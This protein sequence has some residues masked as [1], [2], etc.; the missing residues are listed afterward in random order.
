MKALHILILVPG[1]LVLL[2]MAGEVY[3]RSR[4]LARWSRI[5]CLLLA[6]LIVAW[7][8]LHYKTKFD[9]ASF[10]EIEYWRASRIEY[11]LGGM[12]VGTFVTLLLSG[13]FLKMRKAR[14]SIA[15]HHPDTRKDHGAT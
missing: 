5:A 10:S 14:P 11:W 8:M 15:S 13:E 6:L 7:G 12:I 9:R 4:N 3:P 1:I 2:A